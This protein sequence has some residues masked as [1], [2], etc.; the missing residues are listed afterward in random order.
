MLLHVGLDAV[1]ELS[2]GIREL[3]GGY[4][5]QSDPDRL[6]RMGISQSGECHGEQGDTLHWRSSLRIF[7]SP[8]RLRTDMV[9]A[10]QSTRKRPKIS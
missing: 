6:L 7:V 2:A 4:I 3:T 5:D 10:K 1:V 9:T 8:Q